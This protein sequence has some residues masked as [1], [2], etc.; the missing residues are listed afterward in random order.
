MELDHFVTKGLSYTRSKMF[1]AG[2]VLFLS[3]CKSQS[4]PWVCA[5]EKHKRLL[6]RG[7]CTSLLFQ[8]ENQT[9]CFEMH[10]SCPRADIYTLK[11]RLC[12]RKQHEVHCST[13]QWKRHQKFNQSINVLTS[14]VRYRSITTGAYSSFPLWSNKILLYTQDSSICLEAAQSCMKG[15]NVRL[16]WFTWTF[17]S[18][19]IY[20]ALI[21]NKC[22][23]KTPSN[24]SESRQDTIQCHLTLQDSFLSHLNPPWAER[25]CSV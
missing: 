5:F 11:Y 8:S 17:Q 20:K 2:I 25:F 7:E 9:T 23:Q 14:S 6:C 24:K 21:H 4:F 16:S 22:C 3:L 1:E 13:P 12:H 18:I 19:I 10:Q 15:S